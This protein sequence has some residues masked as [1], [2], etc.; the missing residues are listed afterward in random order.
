M[1][2]AIAA[3]AIGRTAVANDD[4]VADPGLSVPPHGFHEF[5]VLERRVVAGPARPSN[6]RVNK[7][8]EGVDER[9]S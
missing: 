9:K 2:V 8:V 1:A 7:H 3:G 6:F 4:I 5:R